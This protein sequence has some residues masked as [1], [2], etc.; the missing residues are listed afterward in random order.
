MGSDV[1]FYAGKTHPVCQDYVIHRETT[2]PPDY[3]FLADGCS[4]SPHTDTGGR[5]LCHAGKNHILSSGTYLYNGDTTLSQQLVINSAHI[6]CS[7]I[8][9]PTTCLDATLI[10]AVNYNGTTQIN[11]LGDGVVALKSKKGE[12]KI[13][14]FTYGENYPFYLNYKH[15]LHRARYESWLRMQQPHSFRIVDILKPDTVENTLSL[16]TEDDVESVISIHPED[17]EI[18]IKNT[19][20]EFVAVMSDGVESFYKTDE[21]GRM[22]A[23]SHIDIIRSLL[24][25]KNTTGA[26]AQRRVNKFRKSCEKDKIQSHDDVSIGVMKLND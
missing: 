1:A 6:A 9:M 3:I 22:E 14:T 13:I 24:D 20:Y 7:M 15:Y 8:G 11:V 18:K 10:S 17:T 4:S 21:Q 16:F 25:F 23:V 2:D 5:L 26:F 12:V 19:Y